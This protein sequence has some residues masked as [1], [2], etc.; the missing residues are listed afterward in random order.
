M[1]AAAV[2]SVLL[3]ASGVRACDTIVERGRPPVAVAGETAVIVWNPKTRTEHFIRTAD[4]TGVS[5]SM[6]FLVPTPTPPRLKTIDPDA[7][8][9]AIEALEN[10]IAPRVVTVSRPVYRLSSD[11]SLGL[12]G[13]LSADE[14]GNISTASRP[15]SVAD[16]GDDL[17]V[18]SQGRVGGYDTAVLRASDPKAMLSW[19]RRHGFASDAR[20]EGWLKPY[21]DRGWSITAFRFASKSTSFTSEP[22][23][24]RFE[25]NRPFYPYREPTATNAPASRSLRVYL[26]APERRA[27][28]LDGARWTTAPEFAGPVDQATEDELQRGLPLPEGSL[29]GAWLTAF[30]DRRPVRPAS[31]LVFE[32]DAVGQTVEPSPLVRHEDRTVEIPKGLATVAGGGSFALTVTL[33]RRRRRGTKARKVD[34]GPDRTI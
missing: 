7:Y 1:R 27:G 22:I 9:G 24:L 16:K 14:A 18:V 20:L 17:R 12:P 8:R 33:L 11:W 30:L 26:V 28:S 19:L 29:S 15:A 4:F 2:L 23:D 6:G 34:L 32:P 10:R 31:D 5:G 13:S 25:T 3:G 21:V